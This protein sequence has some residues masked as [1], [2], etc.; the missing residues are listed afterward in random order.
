MDYFEDKKRQ[1][2]LL[3]ILK[4]WEGTPFRHRCGVQ[5]IGCDCIHLCV[6]VFEEFELLSLKKG[7]IPNY[8][9]DWHMHNTR[10][11]LEEAILKYLFVYKVSLNNLKNGD[12]V[13]SHYGKAA[14]HTG[15]FFDKHIYQA[16][17]DIGVVSIH[18]NDKKFK[19]QMKYAYRIKE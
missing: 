3:K 7:M 11:V 6:R 5:Q 4:K 9:R 2:K 12:I 13:L 15:I 19:S 1:Q 14:S 16:I 8:P 10:E 17:N 18:V